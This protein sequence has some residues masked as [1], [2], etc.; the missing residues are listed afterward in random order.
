[1]RRKACSGEAINHGKPKKIATHLSFSIFISSPI[2]PPNW[3]MSPKSNRKANYV[4]H[5]CTEIAEHT[6]LIKLSDRL[7]SKSDLRDEKWRSLKFLLSCFVLCLVGRRFHHGESMKTEVFT[8]FFLP[9]CTILLLWNSCT[10]IESDITL[11]SWNFFDSSL[12][13]CM[14]V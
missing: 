10:Y 11:H 13:L 9:L 4:S 7:T 8:V 12:F 1:M 5:S 14:F 6:F 2:T 3:W